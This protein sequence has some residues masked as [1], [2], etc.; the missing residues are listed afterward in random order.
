MA[1]IVD[2]G[3]VA[4]TDERAYAICN[5]IYRFALPDLCERVGRS[6][7]A[8]LLGGLSP[9]TDRASAEAAMSKLVQDQ[10][11]QKHAAASLLDPDP[12]MLVAHAM[13]A[14]AA[15]AAMTETRPW[16]ALATYE[17]PKPYRRRPR[18]DCS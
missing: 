10:T 1:V 11:F 9:I 16:F 18:P 4:K 15:I 5:Y 13:A 17:D 12:K 7:Y 8:R 3:I 14:F 6:D 2:V